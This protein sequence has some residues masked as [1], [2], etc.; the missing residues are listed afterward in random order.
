[1]A[2]YVWHKVVCRKEVLEQYFIDSNP[3]GDVVQIE[4]PYISFNRL[5][6]VK[7]INEYVEKYRIGIYYG[8]GFSWE[9]QLNGM[10]EVKFCTRWEYPIRAIIR[11]LEVA[12]DALWF[13]SEE[14]H[15]YVSK[16]YW[17]ERVKEDILFITDGY[18]R[19]IDKNME[20]ECSLEA[21]DSGVW[22]YLST[23]KDVWQNRE[24]TDDLHNQ[25]YDKHRKGVAN[26]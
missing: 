20:F 4:P 7:S 23:V 17:D 11:L 1:M 15:I 14:N 24:N 13:A 12:D 18:D 8:Y 21:W 25:K 6:G 16:F 9:E 22:Y 26:E 10:C 19:W 3:F 5:F 2:N